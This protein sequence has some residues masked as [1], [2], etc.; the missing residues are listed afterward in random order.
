MAESQ[1]HEKNAKPCFEKLKKVS[2]IIKQHGIN[3]AQ[4]LREDRESKTDLSEAEAAC[5]LRRLDKMINLL[6][7]AIEQA[8]S[9]IIS[10]KVIK[11]EDKI[12]SAYHDNVNVIK[13]GKA[14]GQFEYGNPL[15]IA[16]QKDRVI[17]D[18][19]LY[20]TDVKEPQSTKESIKR[21]TEDLNYEIKSLTGD[22]G[23]QSEA[24]DK[25]L[26]KKAIT[27]GLCSRDPAQFIEK[28]E[29]PSFRKHQKRRAQTEARIGIFKILFSTAHFMNEILKINK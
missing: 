5:I 8:N 28:M 14:G 17:L 15:F 21:L 19:R 26:Q 20:E 6:P 18:W 13:R 24:N 1:A 23:C 12:L 10:N 22:R 3:Y 2:Q 29:D 25:L 11:N 7:K 4:R 16:E 27:S 9:R